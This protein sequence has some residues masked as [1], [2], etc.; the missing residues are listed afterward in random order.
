M[1]NIA[2]NLIKGKDKYGEKFKQ[3]FDFEQFTYFEL[4]EKPQ[5]FTEYGLEGVQSI[6]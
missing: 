6:V 1:Y 2:K 4:W 3:L 5:K